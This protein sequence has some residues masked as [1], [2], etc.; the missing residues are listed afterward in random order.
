MADAKLSGTRVSATSNTLTTPRLVS[1]VVSGAEIAIQCPSWCV[2]DH[3]ESSNLYLEDVRHESDYADLNAKVIGKADNLQLFARLGQSLVSTQA[4]RMAPYLVLD[5]GDD[6]EEL[7]L[8]GADEFA[9][10]LVAFAA[11]IRELTRAARGGTR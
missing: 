7:T 2:I 3:A 9:D 8:D 10:N 5:G 4:H 6:A 1:T 11:Q